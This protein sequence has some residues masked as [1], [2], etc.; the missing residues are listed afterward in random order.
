MNEMKWGDEKDLKIGGRACVGTDDDTYW[1]GYCWY[2]HYVGRV[3][4]GLA[5]LAVLIMKYDKVK[6]W[7]IVVQKPCLSGY[8]VGVLE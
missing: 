6:R 4:S 7:A 8:D 3:P 1:E 5:G 2:H